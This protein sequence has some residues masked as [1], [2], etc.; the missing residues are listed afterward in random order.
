VRDV[1]IDACEQRTS[2]AGVSFSHVVTSLLIVSTSGCA[3]ALPP[4]QTTT[5]S[6]STPVLRFEPD[7]PDVRLMGP[8]GEEYGLAVHEFRAG[9]YYERGMMT[10]YGSVCDGPCTREMPRG[11]YSFALSKH[12][13]RP[14][15]VGTLSLEG[16]AMV[17]GTYIDHR[18]LRI[19]GALVG[20]GGVIAGAALFALASANSGSGADLPLGV[21]AAGS[22]VGGLTLGS[23]LVLQRDKASI[24]VSTL[25]LPPTPRVQGP[26]GFVPAG[27]ATPRGPAV[28]IRF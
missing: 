14:L 16:P 24:E 21:A 10:T 15:P 27:A 28:N 2:H 8:T 26:T 22:A 23:V 3:E 11:E 20:L 1:R 19:V 13:R 17:R 6:A 5:F 18:N 7:A 12:G 25:T 4:H 9:T